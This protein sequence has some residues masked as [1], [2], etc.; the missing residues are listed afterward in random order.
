[1]TAGCNGSV[2]GNLG[3]LLGIQPGEQEQRGARSREARPE[4]R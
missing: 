2:R 3:S 1:V 4:G